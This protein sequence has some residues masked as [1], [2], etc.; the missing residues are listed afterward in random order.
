MTERALD[1][2]MHQDRSGLDLVALMIDGVHFAE[3][4]CVV[5]LGISID[6]TKVPLGVVEGSTENATVVKALL[7]DLRDRGL[8]VCR[9]ILVVIDGAKALAT[10]VCEIFDRPVTQ[11]CQ[12]HTIRN[13]EGHLDKATAPVSVSTSPSASDAAAPDGREEDARRV[14]QPRPAEGRSDARALARSLKPANPPS[15]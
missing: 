2:M 13:V 8:D 14:P 11:R 10:A 1:E 9:P 12:L 7:T 3:H 4:L 5:A 6:G 15:P